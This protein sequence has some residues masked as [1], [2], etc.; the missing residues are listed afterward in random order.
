MNFKLCWQKHLSSL[1][2]TS[3]STS[4]L[5]SDSDTE[6]VEIFGGSG[7]EEGEKDI[8]AEDLTVDQDL[9]A[10]NPS[11]IDDNQSDEP[12]FKKQC[13]PERLES[14]TAYIDIISPLRTQRTKETIILGRHMSGE[15]GCLTEL[16]S[17]KIL[18]HRYKLVVEIHKVSASVAVA[19]AGVFA[20]LINKIYKIMEIFE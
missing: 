19:L 7:R 6:S 17:S 16:Y 18:R 9:E 10:D 1:S 14:L 15:G 2:A 5:H 4:A 12:P 3:G 13:R 11:N 8:F 20:I